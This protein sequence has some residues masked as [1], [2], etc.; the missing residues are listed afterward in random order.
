VSKTSPHSELNSPDSLELIGIFNVINW[1]ILIIYFIIGNIALW[2]N[3][4]WF[5]YLKFSE[6]DYN[7]NM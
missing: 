3:F 7:H 2:L 5:D 1:L 4:P 6:F